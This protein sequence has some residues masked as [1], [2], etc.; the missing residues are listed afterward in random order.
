MS[1]NAIIAAVG[2]VVLAI[3]GVILQAPVK[4]IVCGE[5]PA[6]EAVVAPAAE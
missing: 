5:A 1:K 2:A 4:S 6:P 3:L